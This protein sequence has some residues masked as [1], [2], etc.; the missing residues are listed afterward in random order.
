MLKIPLGAVPNQ[1]LNVTLDNQNVSLSIYTLPRSA[2][3]YSLTQ[4]PVKP[5]EPSLIQTTFM[6]V[7]LSGNTIKTCIQAVNQMRMLADC[8]YTAFVGDFVFL[9]T[10]GNTNPI[11]TGFG[12]NPRYQLI[13]L[14]AADLAATSFG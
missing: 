8:Q 12:T 1:T 11:Y 2:Q 10:Q 6:D 4:T 5:A 9:D 13:Y 14:E 7:L 3:W